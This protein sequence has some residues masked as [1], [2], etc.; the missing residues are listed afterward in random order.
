MTEVDPGNLAGLFYTGSSPFLV[1]NPHFSRTLVEASRHCPLQASENIYDA[2]GLMLWAGGRPIEDRLLERLRDRKLRKPIEL[3][4]HA[5]DPAAAAEIASTFDELLQS[6]PDLS[7]ALGKSVDAVRQSIAAI[8]PNP[9]E[10]MLLSVLRHAGT[11]RLAHAVRVAALALG[12][13]RTIALEPEL[14]RVLARAALFHDVG[15]LYLPPELFSGTGVRSPEQMR[16][17]R[18]HPVLGAQVVVELARSGRTVAHLVATSHE[19]LDGG[20]YPRGTAGADLSTPEQA[21][22]FAEAMATPLESGTNRLRRAAIAAR[23]IRGEFEARMVNWF[24]GC[25][26]NREVEPIDAGQADAAGQELVQIHFVLTRMS[27]LLAAAEGEAAVVRDF[28]ARWKARL[29]A[30]LWVLHATG[31]A[32]II[33]CGGSIDPK[34]PAERIEMHVMAQELRFRIRDLRVSV[35]LGRAGSPELGTSALVQ[36]LLGALEASEPQLEAGVH[37][38]EEGPV[39][40]RWSKLFSVGVQEI[41][42]QHRMI[43]Q[44]L[45]HL[46]ATAAAADEPDIRRDILAQLVQYVK[47]HFATEEALM[48]RHGYPE[49]AAHIAQHQALTQRVFEMA[50]LIDSGHAPSRQDLIA[51]LRRWLI[52]HILRSDRALGEALHAA[53]VH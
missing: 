1:A 43:V 32:E 30:L 34:D 14:L 50:A 40:L 39:A 53:G 38:A 47:L 28:A 46:Y 7:A 48:R 12:A 11:D 20:G 13:A 51:F 8:V 27:D 37:D 42:E 33:A 16:S 41:D 26:R 15:E 49:T 35:E 52:F 45:N 3:C 24:A 17:I 23:L 4:V 36:Q 22:Q 9:T 44:M 19:R 25:A 2:N 10:L 29:E 21:L 18:S 5:I 6:S 31:I